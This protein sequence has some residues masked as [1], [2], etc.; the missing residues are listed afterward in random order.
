MSDLPQQNTIVQYL[1]DGVEDQYLFAFY[2]PDD[3]DIEVYVTPVGQAPIPE[4]D[5]QELGVAYTVTQ[6]V[7]PITGGYITFLPGYIPAAGSSVTLNRNVQASLD[8][9]F[10]NG[11]NF[12][13]ANLDAALD[14]LLL[15]IQQNQTYALQ[16]NLS[17]RVNTYLTNEQATIQ[18]NTQLQPLLPGY[19][20]QGAADGGVVAVLLEENPDVSTLRSELASQSPTTNGASLVGYYDQV[21]SLPTTVKAFLDNIVTFMQTQLEAQLWQPGDLK[22]HASATVPTGWLSC[23]GSAV[24]RTTYAALFAAIGTTW[25]SGD[26]STTF[27]L[28]DFRRRTSVGSGGSGSATLGNAVGNV[29]GEE[30]HTQTIAEMPAH[31]HTGSY[32][33]LNTFNA[34]SGGAPVP[35][36][37]GG[38]AHGNTPVSV[39]SQGGGTPFNVIQPSGVVLKI[40]KT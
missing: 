5:I 3:V 14:K 21:N 40:I 29:G 17:Y 24:S 8:V 38:S 27:N 34:G 30:T 22:D 10:A 18:A 37:S 16:R 11:Q 6:N 15:L 23:D 32:W 13:G 7:D 25:G 4:S 35:I 9:E 26:G 33:N 12:N 36:Y 39:A 20:W 28:P 31:D 19:I 1:A 2:V